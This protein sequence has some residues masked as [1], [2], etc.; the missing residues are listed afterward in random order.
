MRGGLGKK[1]RQRPTLPH[2]NR[3]VPSA[4]EGLTTVFGMGTGEPL[5]N[6]HRKIGEYAREGV[7]SLQS[8]VFATKWQPTLIMNC[9]LS[10]VD[11]ELSTPKESVTGRARAEWMRNG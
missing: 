11:C 9:R 2:G 1:F 6:S 4:L 3:A 8:T 5:R 10:T 7:D